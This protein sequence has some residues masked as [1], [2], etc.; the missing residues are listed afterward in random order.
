MNRKVVNAE[1]EIAYRLSPEKE[2][3]AAVATSIMREGFYESASN[4]AA[5]VDVLVQNLDPN[6]VANLAVY[7]RTRLNLRA[8]PLYLCALIAKH[9]PS[10]IGLPAVVEN[11]IQRADELGGMLEKYAIVNNRN[12]KERGSLKML[13]KK[14]SKGVARA[15]GKFN[16]YAF[17]KY[18]NASE[19]PLRQ[20]M[21]LTHPKPNSDSEE[22]FRKI[23]CECLDTPVTWETEISAH[24][25]NSGV[26]ERLFRNGNLP[27]MA[28]LRNL[29]NIIA[30]GVNEEILREIA[31]F[32]SSPVQVARGK[33]L[34]F[35]Y[36][37]AWRELRFWESDKQSFWKSAPE[38]I[39]D[40]L[41]TA[42]C[43][44]IQNIPMFVDRRTL[45]ASD[46]SGSMNWTAAKNS[47][48]R[49]RDIG[50]VLGTLLHSKLENS[51]FGIFATKWLPVP[52][53]TNKPLS[54][55]SMLAD[56][57]SRAVGG[58]TEGHLAIEWALT[59]RKFYDKFV[60]FTDCMWWD[61]NDS[62]WNHKN[63]SSAEVL[64]RQ[65][66]NTI[67]PEAKMFYVDVAGTE[68]TPCGVGENNTY[69]VSGWNERVFDYLHALESGDDI[70]DTL[71]TRVY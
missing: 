58:G 11:C 61:H 54:E 35:R 8:T 3:F 51:D 43:S 13:D 49:L 22:L 20:A 36:Y 64:W 50:L 57:S 32:I 25:N 45:V 7:A 41:E 63:K 39:L 62:L 42:A 56:G 60:F 1:G 14:I 17:G 48:I 19:I 59:N 38:F 6:F 15:F 23:A 44:S 70:I 47:N 34:P 40:S 18:K 71:K 21:F 24:G 66:L 10:F 9:H 69:F 29:R 33:Q 68:S 46:V 16:E 12:P 53:T 30:S 67:N 28:T 52:L 31:D 55:S 27:Y 65:Y 2:L 5:R 4:R 26:W 37:S